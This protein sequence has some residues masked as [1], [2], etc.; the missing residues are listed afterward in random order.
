MGNWIRFFVGTPRRFLATAAV[1]GLIA[2][3]INPG[4]LRTAVERLLVEVSPLL[5]PVISLII[6]IGALRIIFSGFFRR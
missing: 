4:L 5:G 6:V 2:V 1:L 3:M